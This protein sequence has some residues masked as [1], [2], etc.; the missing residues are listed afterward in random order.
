M[1]H[2]QHIVL[3]WTRSLH[4][5]I[6]ET[7]NIVAEGG[8]GSQHVLVM[9]EFSCRWLRSEIHIS[10]PKMAGHIFGLGHLHTIFVL[11][12]R[13]N[14]GCVRQM[15]GMNAL[16]ACNHLI[17]SV[18]HI[19]ISTRYSRGCGVNMQNRIIMGFHMGKHTNEIMAYSPKPSE[20][21]TDALLGW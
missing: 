14:V 9:R 3:F 12:R 19:N 17:S 2:D 16:W 18:W 8:G 11:F 1:K 4:A 5:S 13:T 20:L 6:L 21:S 15:N 10:A 7:V